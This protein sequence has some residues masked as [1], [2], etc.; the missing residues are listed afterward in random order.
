[1]DRILRQHFSPED[2][3]ERESE[4]PGGDRKRERGDAGGVWASGG[5]VRKVGGGDQSTARAEPEPVVPDHDGAAERETGRVEP[6]WSEYGRDGRRDRSGEIRS[7]A[8]SDGR[9]RR[10]RWGSGIQPGPL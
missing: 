7:D 10:D 9:R 5:A 8:E 6:R 4:Y 3:P 1:I 2:G